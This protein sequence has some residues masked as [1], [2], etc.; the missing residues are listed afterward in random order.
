MRAYARID[1]GI[2]VEIVD[3][4]PNEAG[5]VVPIERKFTAE[6]VAT[7]I[8]ITDLDPKP[9]ERWTYNGEAFAEPV[10]TVPTEAELTLQVISKRNAFLGI[11]NEATAG[12][13]DAYIAGLL[14]EVDIAI[15]RAYA[16]YKLALNK[17]DRQPGYP[18]TIDWPSAP[19]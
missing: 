13:A 15:F 11:A 18:H 3:L 6:F 12:M 19:A 17:I 7:L 1:S 8:E 4:E 10:P 2:V 16:A 9:G 14:D 5:E